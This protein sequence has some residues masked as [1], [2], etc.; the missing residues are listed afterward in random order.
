MSR[1]F[2]AICHWQTASYIQQATGFWNLCDLAHIR[3]SMH[4]VESQ[5]FGRSSVTWRA[6][7]RRDRDPVAR[8][9]DHEFPALQIVALRGLAAENCKA[10]HGHALRVFA[11]LQWRPEITI[12][13]DARCGS[14]GTQRS[15]R[16]ANLAV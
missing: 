8:C 9:A 12:S 10:R 5:C 14:D 2:R 16:F 6:F 13:S 4:D 1:G 7:A 15:T 11:Q 3:S